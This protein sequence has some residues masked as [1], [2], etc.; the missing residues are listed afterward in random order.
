MAVLT[1]AV[2]IGD[3]QLHIDDDF[4]GVTGNFAVKIDSELLLVGGVDYRDGLT[5]ALKFPATAAHDSGATVTRVLDAFTQDA[6]S[7]F[8]GA[9]GG[10]TVRLLGPYTVNHDDADLQGAGLLLEE[11]AAGTWLWGVQVI[12][13]QAWDNVGDLSFQV[14]LAGDGGS[15]ISGG[16][17][18][19]SWGSLGGG[20]G[21]SHPVI[22]PADASTVPASQTVSFQP[23]GLREDGGLY[24]AF[25]PIEP[26]TTGRVL[27]YALIVE[28][29]A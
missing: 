10:Q 28:P 1:R 17:Y 4:A 15:G 20:N 3:T 7:P 29:S 13:T 5:L 16:W 25:Y 27:I 24:A 23:V 8:A 12:G 26:S 6:T 21:P 19:E 14:S 9:G 22:A 11:L 18:T 2:A